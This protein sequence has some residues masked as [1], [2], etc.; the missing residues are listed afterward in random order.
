MLIEKL[1]TY[2]KLGIAKLSGTNTVGLTGLLGIAGLRGT[3][4]GLFNLVEVIMQGLQN[5]G[6]SGDCQT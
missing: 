2:F 5:L 1:R 4:G 6:I 3:N